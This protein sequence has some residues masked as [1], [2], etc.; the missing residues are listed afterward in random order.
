MAAET[1]HT[2]Q[3]GPAMISRATV[4]SCLKSGISNRLGIQNRRESSRA[5][6]KRASDQ[7]FEYTVDDGVPRSFHRGRKHGLP[8]SLGVPQGR[9]S[10]LKERRHAAKRS[11]HTE[12]HQ[13]DFEQIP[14]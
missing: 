6:S 11:A 13:A 10:K 3:K 5:A 12:Q 8:R 2:I 9:A 1:S 14:T 7:D 4:P